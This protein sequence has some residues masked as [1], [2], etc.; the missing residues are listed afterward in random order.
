MS[1][2]IKNKNYIY[3]LGQ[4]VRKKTFEGTKEIIKH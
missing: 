3:L 4:K 1:S 2:R